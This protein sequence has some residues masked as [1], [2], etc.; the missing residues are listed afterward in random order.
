[1]KVGLGKKMQKNNFFKIFK[2][3][4]LWDIYLNNFISGTDV[5]PKEIC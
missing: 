5:K 3:L 4:N 2:S 1:M